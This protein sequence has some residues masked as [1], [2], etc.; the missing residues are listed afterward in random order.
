MTTISDRSCNDEDSGDSLS[1]QVFLGVAPQPFHSKRPGD[2]R[3]GDLLKEGLHGDVVFVLYPCDIG[4]R[5]NGGR[6]G[7][8]YGPARFLHFLERMGSLQNE[9][10]NVDLSSLSL[11]YHMINL[12]DIDEDDLEEAHYRL[13]KVVSEVLANGGLPFV[14]GGGNDQ[15]FANWRALRNLLACCNDASQRI[16]VIN[17]DAHL[18]VRSLIDGKSNSGTPFR[19]IVDYECDDNAKITTQLTEFAAQGSQ[20][21]KS[22]TN[23]VED[24]GGTILWLKDVIHDVPI[25]FQEVI[26]QWQQSSNIQN[27]FV[28]FDLDSIKASDCPG[29]SCPANTGLSAEDA[30]SI[31]RI[32]GRSSIV[33]LVDMSEMNPVIEDYVTP[34]LAVQMAY[35]FLIGYSQRQKV[36][37][38][39]RRPYRLRI[40][41]LS[42]L[43][44]VE[45]IQDQGFRTGEYM[46]KLQ[47]IQD[48]AILVD[49]D[50]IIAYV[51][52]TKDAPQVNDYDIDTILDGHGK[53][54]IPGLCDAH[55]HSVW[56]G[57]RVHEF[58][59]K[60]AG[61]SYM[62][63]H[64]MGG[65]INYT[66]KHTREADEEILYNDLVK[67][68]K[69]MNSL[70]TTLVE[71]KSGYGLDTLTE[72]KM[73]RVIDRA[74]KDLPFLDVVGNFCGAHSVPEGST[75]EQALK[76]VINE[77]IPVL[78]KEQVEGRLSSVKLIDVFAD[79]GV[80]SATSAK[81]VLE[82]G[83]KIG[84]LGNFHGDE[85]TYQGCGELAGKLKCRAVSHLEQVSNAGIAS[86]KESHTAAVLLPTTAYVL[87]ITPPPARNLIDS[88]VPVALGSDFNPNAH[89]LSMPHVMN[90]ACITM[91][92]TVEEALVASTLNAAYSMGMETTHGSL[93]VGKCG[94]IVLVEAPRWEHII[95]Q[96]GGLPPLCA[97]I[98]D[99]FMRHTFPLLDFTS[100]GNICEECGRS[101]SRCEVGTHERKDFAPQATDESLD[102][103][104]E[105]F[106]C[107][108]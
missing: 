45:D 91:K 85:L 25:K 84:L 76:T 94:D 34:R 7:A 29:V 74:Q 103:E 68:L 15:S 55:T 21:S 73:L 4:V 75:E 2:A 24:K 16:G 11:S 58:A 96:F 108:L 81:Q 41:H 93:E 50:G 6:V 100:R 32:A 86:M 61:A 52:T 27:G 90:L 23:Y 33:K 95:Y 60:L 3:L 49:Q 99:G 18:D 53:A 105:Q 31:M 38:L 78:A 5:R 51:G 71:C 44:C 70:G 36:L 92:M 62:D 63:I 64:K 48:G 82:A 88:G 77:M 107:N 97:V 14:V 54:A 67:R 39:R 9:E 40:S 1:K 37:P 56:A 79:E 72:M 8:Q 80:F 22:N 28:S 20:C 87:R 26:Q 89:C 98:K 43:I 17:I 104:T 102:Q 10:Y 46:S 30:L 83:A 66:V 65:G 12:E 19:Q 101:C 106:Y 59:M 42:Q 57:D 13:T 35:N 47:V 69:C